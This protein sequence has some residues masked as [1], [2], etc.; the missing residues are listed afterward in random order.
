MFMKIIIKSSI[1]EK[2]IANY[3]FDQ[4]NSKNF[5]KIFLQISQQ[6]LKKDLKIEK[7]IK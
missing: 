1:I 7:K 3:Y 6:K 2:E 5:L 4:I